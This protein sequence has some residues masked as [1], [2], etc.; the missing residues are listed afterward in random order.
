MH[1]STPRRRITF[2]KPIAAF[3][4]IQFMLADMEIAAET[5]RQYA[6]YVAQLIDAGLPHTKA[7]ISKVLCQ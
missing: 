6:R 1:Q 2:G 4:A 5:S 3:Q 7:A